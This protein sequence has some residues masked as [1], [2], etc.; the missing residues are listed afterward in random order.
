MELLY[1]Q[2][3]ENND[4]DKKGRVKIKVPH[5]HQDVSDVALLPWAKS[6]N[7]GTGGSTTQGKSSI[8][9]KNSWVWVEFADMPHYKKPYYIADV[10]LNGMHP[11]QLFDTNT[12]SHITGWSSNY[13]DVKYEYYANGICIAVSSN[14]STPEIAIYHPQGSSIFIDQTGIINIKAGTTTIEKTVLGETLKTKLEALIDAINAITVPTPTG[15]SGTPVNAATF[16][17]LKGQL[18]AI[19]SPKVKNN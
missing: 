13:P 11:H 9:E 17:S 15:P 16:T 3:V 18:T 5:I 6:K 8:P 14:A 19:L 1:A 2:V 10:T 7:I 12:K 4:P